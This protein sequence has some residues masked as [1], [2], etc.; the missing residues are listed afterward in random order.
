[1]T[2]TYHSGERIQGT[3]TDATAIAGGWKEL[4]RTTLSN[5]PSGSA[6]FTSDFSSA[7]GWTATGS[8]PAVNTG[9]E[10]I[11]FE[12]ATSANIKAQLTYDLTSTSN[13][14]WI[15]R[16]K[17]NVTTFTQPTTE[18]H[19]FFIGLSSSTSNLNTSEDAIGLKYELGT[20][21]LD[22]LVA[23]DTNGSAIRATTGDNFTHTSAVETLYVE[24]I[25][26][27]ATTY[28]VNLRT[29]SHSGTLVEG[30]TGL[31]VSAS[32]TGLQYLKIGSYSDNAGNGELSGTIND[33]QFWNDQT[34]GAGDDI[35]VSSLDD[36]RYYM[37]LGHGVNDGTPQQTLRFNGD[38]QSNYGRNYSDNGNSQT[39]STTDR[40][41][42]GA[43][44]LDGSNSLS[45]SYVANKSNKEKIV[46]SQALDSHTAG[47]SSSANNI[48]RYE[49]TGKWSNATDAINSITIHNPTTGN[50][51]VGSECIILGYD[52]TDTHT[53]NFWE[54]LKTIS[55]TGQS[56]DDID[57]GIF[58]NKKYLWVQL[59]C[60]GTTNTTVKMTFNN[61]TDS[62]YGYRFSNNGGSDDT[63]EGVSKAFIKLHNTKANATKFLNMFIVNDGTHEPLGLSNE[64]EDGGSSVG[65]SNDPDRSD[66]FFKRSTATAI[67]RIN[68]NNDDTGN[69]TDWEL[70]IWGSN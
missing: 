8:T 38:D 23:I 9:T 51:D 31:T 5:T 2:V 1:M 13:T 49:A 45:V 47:V 24:I 44:S 64:V 52:P 26:Q 16:C 33:I 7:T 61:S 28:D 66:C 36:K 40:I 32:T 27:S 65:S 37:V 3:S 48:R 20:G 10:K 25:R 58:T 29:G 12:S 55:L 46:V 35:T 34:I 30:K 14:A 59:W 67:T 22:R 69:F 17:L 39:G 54:L 19:R 60:K 53:D 70:R 43:A 50:F 4:G 15:L 63:T 18:Y 57:S 11:D 6:T 56:T 68:F 41:S 62:T 21:S 42:I